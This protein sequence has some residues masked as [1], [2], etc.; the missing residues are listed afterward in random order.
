[1]KLF[2]QE[3]IKVGESYT[4]WCEFFNRDNS[5]RQKSCCFG[6]LEK[7]KKNL[8]KTSDFSTFLL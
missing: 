5:H 3:G 6:H 1:M 2:F 7:N 8:V 4:K